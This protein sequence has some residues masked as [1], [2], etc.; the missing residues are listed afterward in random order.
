MRPPTPLPRRTAA[1]DCRWSPT[2]RAIARFE[3]TDHRRT[4]AA[5][6]SLDAHSDRSPAP[7]RLRMTAEQST[8]WWQPNS[9]TIAARLKSP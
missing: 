2:G 9:T 3:A 5:N 7:D 6:P 1:L 8:A 4:E